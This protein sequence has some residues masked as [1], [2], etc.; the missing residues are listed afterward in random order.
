MLAKLFGKQEATKEIKLIHQSENAEIHETNDF[1]IGLGYLTT[2][3][4]SLLLLDLD[5]TVLT[6]AHSLGTDQWFDYALKKQAQTSN[7]PETAKKQVIDFYLSVIPNIRLEDVHSVEP[8]T[9]QRINELQAAGFKVL[10]LTS[11]GSYLQ[12]ATLTQLEHLNIDLNQ[13]PYQNLTKILS[14][15]PESVMHNGIIMA[16][17]KDKG[18]CL[19]E[20][21]VV[22][23]ET[24]VMY[25]D[26]LSNLEKVRVAIKRY[27]EEHL[28]LD[29]DFMPRKF[30][31]IRYGRLDHRIQ[32]LN[33]KIVEIQTQTYGGVLP[34]E[35]AQAI[36]KVQ[37]KQDRTYYATLNFDV[38]SGSLTVYSPIPPV[39]AKMR[40]FLPDLNKH[41]VLGK[42]IE[43][44]GMGRQ[45]FAYKFN[46][47]E[48]LHVY[49]QLKKHQLISPT[50]IRYYE[51][52]INDRNRLLTQNSRIQLDQEGTSVGSKSKNPI[53]TY[54]DFRKGQTLDSAETPPEPEPKDKTRDR[55]RLSQSNS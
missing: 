42:V 49:E 52:F 50:N 21:G 54:Y 41:Q 7:D 4:K 15:G 27:N 31:G 32:N 34:D 37:N 33:E 20:S 25:D 40:E 19:L 38:I 13:P 12:E 36:L 28:A 10:A 11:R 5:N 16:G 53:V 30:I 35:L 43:Y 8:M 6:Y 46:R 24:I 39:A 3:D 48:A 44:F 2:P 23:P 14:L 22:L 47:N 51:Q 1:E 45:C 26:K 18:K 29:P 17:G 55:T 9:P